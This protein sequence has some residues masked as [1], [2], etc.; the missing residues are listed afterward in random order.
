MDRKNY[1]SLIHCE[2]TKTPGNK[3]GNVFDIFKH[4]LP[5]QFREFCP[6]SALQ[7]LQYCHNVWLRWSEFNTTL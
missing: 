3:A 1:T 6:D 5:L 2:N 4:A 7:F